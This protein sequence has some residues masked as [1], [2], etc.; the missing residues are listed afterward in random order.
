M[1]DLQAELRD[2]VFGAIDELNGQRAPGERLVKSVETALTGEAGPLDS[3]AFVN[4]VVALEQRLDTVFGTPVSLLDDEQLDPTASQFRT[5]Q[6][7]ID[8]LHQMQPN[9][10]DV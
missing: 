8:Y 6:S 10:S 3:L 9:A 2:A 1:R 7:L 5:V 4:F